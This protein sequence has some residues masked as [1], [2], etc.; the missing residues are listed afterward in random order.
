MRREEGLIPVRRCFWDKGWSR[1][2]WAKQQED[3][4]RDPQVPSKHKA[5]WLVVCLG[6]TGHPTHLQKEGQGPFREQSGHPAP[7][8]G[9]PECCPPSSGQDCGE[10]GLGVKLTRKSSSQN[11]LPLTK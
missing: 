4:P 8:A 9:P 7:P 1:Q 3:R 6:H 10:G 11:T 5:P 2:K